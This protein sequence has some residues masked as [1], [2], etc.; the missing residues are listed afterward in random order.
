MTNYMQLFLTILFG[1]SCWAS[2]QYVLDY[3]FYSNKN[4]F[5]PLAKP[6]IAFTLG[7]VIYSYVL[8]ALGFGGLYSH[9]IFNGLF[10]S[11]VA[12]FIFQVLLHIKNKIAPNN[13][14]KEFDRFTPSREWK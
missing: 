2:G 11:G 8:T 1:C 9:L 7:N 5:F 3:F 6:V 14:T 13:A 12:L 4:H 10:L